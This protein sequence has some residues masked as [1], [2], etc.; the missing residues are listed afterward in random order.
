MWFKFQGEG[1]SRNKTAQSHPPPY[2]HTAL[3]LSLCPFQIKHTLVGSSKST[4]VSWWQRFLDLLSICPN[5]IQRAQYS[6][7]RVP[8]MVI[9]YPN[10]CRRWEGW[11]ETLGKHRISA[12]TS[13]YLYHPNLVNWNFFKILIMFP[14]LPAPRWHVRV[15]KL[16]CQELCVGHKS[17][18]KASF[19]FGD[20]KPLAKTWLDA[21]ACAPWATSLRLFIFSHRL[22]NLLLRPGNCISA[23]PKA[24]VTHISSSLWQWWKLGS[25]SIW[26]CESSLWGT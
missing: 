1:G 17:E 12:F 3:G 23:C 18:D 4:K 26:L 19:H 7:L 13:P 11:V 6:Q 22:L 24:T 20:I 8:P 10:G 9:R 14:T 25:S 5:T 21:Y 15:L 2:M 16:S